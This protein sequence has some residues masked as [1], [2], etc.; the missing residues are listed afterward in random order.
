MPPSRPGSI[1]RLI[2]GGD[3]QDDI[4]FYRELESGKEHLW[5]LRDDLGESNDPLKRPKPSLKQSAINR[6]K[7]TKN[8]DP[9]ENIRKDLVLAPKS[10]KSLSLRKGKWMYIPSRGSGGFTG[11]KPSDHAWGGAPAAAFAGS[12]NS[13]IVNGKIKKN[14]PAA[15]LYDL[16]NDVRQTKNLYREYPEVVSEMEA[17]LSRYR[18]R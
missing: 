8:E 9:K 16:Q 17:R 7:G 11:S 5:S 4:K 6:S 10:S 18:Q 1:R 14:A 2:L 12:E 3:A 13:D 15:Q